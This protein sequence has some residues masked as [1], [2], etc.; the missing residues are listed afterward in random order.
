MEN[1]I[2]SVYVLINSVEMITY[3]ILLV[4]VVFVAVR[5][6]VHNADVALVEECS[7]KFMA[8]LYDAKMRAK[9]QGCNMYVLYD[10]S[11]QKFYITGE[12]MTEPEEASFGEGKYLYY[13]IPKGVNFSVNF[14]VIA[15]HIRAS[16]LES[17]GLDKKFEKVK[18]N[19]EEKADKKE[20]I[21]YKEQAEKIDSG[22]EESLSEPMLE[23]LKVLEQVVNNVVE[24]LGNAE[25]T[26][27]FNPMSILFFHLFYPFLTSNIK[28]SK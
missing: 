2:Q 6:R 17:F 1:L 3:V 14:K 20:P 12:D 23:R 19:K 9:N 18:V 16:L 8:F 25:M 26:G 13:I 21:K 10:E 28:I 24:K 15:S 4:F 22:K 11:Q 27:R 5:L 7:Q